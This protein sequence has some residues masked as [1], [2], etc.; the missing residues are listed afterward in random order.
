MSL[1][2]SL[3][4]VQGEQRELQPVE[5]GGGGAEEEA[6]EDGENERRAGQYGAGEGGKLF[7]SYCIA[8]HSTIINM[9]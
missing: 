7:V 9:K 8:S 1:L 6:G 4:S 3:C 5:R 2:C